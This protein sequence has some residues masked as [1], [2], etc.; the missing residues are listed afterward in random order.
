MHRVL[1]LPPTLY[2]PLT[3]QQDEDAKMSHQSPLESTKH[4]ATK[5][6]T[7]TQTHTDTHTYTLT[8]THTH[9]HAR[10]HAWHTR[11]GP[12][13]AEVGVGARP[14]FT[15]FHRFCKS[16]IEEGV[17]QSLSKREPPLIQRKPLWVNLLNILFCNKYLTGVYM[18]T[19]P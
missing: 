9:T 7:H 13:L 19:E 10:K 12:A 1:G 17:P 3:D 4:A 15:E 14:C 2:T 8:R 18:R 5:H 11:A 6:I 16:L